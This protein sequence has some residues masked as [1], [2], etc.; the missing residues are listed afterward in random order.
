MFVGPF[1]RNL[2]SSLQ[3]IGEFDQLIQNLL[4]LS[5][6]ARPAGPSLDLEDRRSDLINNFQMLAL[7]YFPDLPFRHQISF[8]VF[9]E[10][11]ILKDYH[12]LSGFELD[13]ETL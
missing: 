1:R 3:F 12:A 6:L 10:P 11:C 4:A 13:Q 8:A 7:T 9:I 5:M 2:L